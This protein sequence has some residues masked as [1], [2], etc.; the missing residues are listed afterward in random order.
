MSGQIA[1]QRECWDIVLQ[2]WE[3]GLSFR[4]R[5]RLAMY[6][7]HALVKCVPYLFLCSKL[8]QDFLTSDIGSCAFGAV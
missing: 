8:F 4:K 6:F 5:N 2:S 3:N 1:E 7:L